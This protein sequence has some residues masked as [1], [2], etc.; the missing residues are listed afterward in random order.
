MASVSSH[1][2][3][4][5]HS[6]QMRPKNSR[7]ALICQALQLIPLSALATEHK[8]APY[9]VQEPPQGPVTLIPRIIA[10]KGS[11][12]Y[13]AGK[14]LRRLH[15]PSLDLSNIMMPGGDGHKPRDSARLPAIGVTCLKM[16]SENLS[17]V[18][19]DAQDQ[20][21]FP[22]PRLLSVAVLP[23]PSPGKDR[24]TSLPPPTPHTTSAPQHPEP[25]HPSYACS[26]HAQA[27]Y[28]QQ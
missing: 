15:P 22:V 24:T 12:P 10:S 6:F 28:P 5:S 3:P 21:R 26:Y 8:R 7:Q 2:L 4:L 19:T 1:F 27:S 16:I 9:R 13:L 18:P 11:F 20:V 23:H 17:C 14:A 25:E